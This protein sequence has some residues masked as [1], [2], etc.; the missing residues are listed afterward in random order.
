MADDDDD[1]GELD[2]VLSHSSGSDS[3]E[4]APPDVLLEDTTNAKTDQSRDCTPVGGYEIV[5]PF[6]N[7]C[8]ETWREAWI[9]GTLLT[10]DE[11][12]LGWSGLGAHELTFIPRKP[13]DL[14]IMVKTVVCSAS[15]IILVCEI[16]EGKDKMRAKEFV[17]E[18]G[19]TTATCL[20]LTAPWWGQGK[21]LIA[22]A[23][24]G[25][26]RA[27]FALLEKDVYAVMNVKTAHS[28]FP[29]AKLKEAMKQRGDAMHM[30]LEFSDKCMEGKEIYAS[31]HM[32]MQPM[33]LVHTTGSS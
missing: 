18:W 26:L 14:G 20:R 17:K 30:K 27:A 11:S 21:I 7:V 19:T 15:G 9:P 29:K 2:E 23:W 33:T 8:Q 10:I 24:F 13:C 4:D 16:M 25:S 32:D 6:L 3:D 22:D 31:A 5:I 1:E 28:G 12:M